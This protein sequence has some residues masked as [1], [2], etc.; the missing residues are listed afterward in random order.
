MKKI[1]CFLL[2]TQGVYAQ[3]DSSS[4]KIDLVKTVF[5]DDVVISSTRAG[6]NT[7]TTF[8]TISKEELN[9]NN[10]GQDL[11]F[12]L[13]NTPGVV[14]T[15]DAG[16]GVGY[17]GI[18]IR[19]SDATRVNVTLNGIPVNDAE[20]Q[21]TYWV[22]LP[23]VVSSA[24]SI[25]IQR[26]IGSSTNGG[27]AFGGTLSMQTQT[28]SQKHFVEANVSMGSFNTFK[29]NGKIGTGIHKGFFAEGSASWITSD[30]YIERA[31]SNLLSYFCQL[32]YMKNNTLLKL[33]YFAGQEKTY[34]AWNG[35]PQDSLSTNR[36]FNDLGTDY[37]QHF[38][39]YKNQTDNYSQDYFQL[40]FAQ[41]LPHHLN[42]NAGLFATLGHG[43]YEEYKA[44]QTFNNY[45]ENHDTLGLSSDLVRQKWLKNVFYGGTF[46]LN[47]EHKNIS[48]TLGGLLGQYRGEN[49]GKVI[50]AQNISDFDKNQKFYDGH[51]VK[52]DFSVYAKFS[53]EILQKVN[54]YID[55]QYRYV[56][57]SANGIDDDKSNYTF[58]NQ[59]HFFNPKAGILYKIKPQHHLY[60]SYA[61][62]NREPNRD[63]V[64]AALASGKTVKPETMHNVEVGYK[65]LHRKYPFTINYY[66]M[67]YK[68][69]LVLT[70]K[71]NDVGNPIKEN[72]PVSSRMGV[73][74][75][76]STNIYSPHPHPLSEGEG[77]N[78]PSPRKVFAINYNFSY[79]LNKIKSFDEYI[80]T[81]DDYYSPLDSLTQIITHKNSNISFSPSIVASLEF[82]AYPVKGLEISLMNKAVS[83]QYL[84]NTSNESRKLK[85][86]FYSNLRI[87][88]KLPLKRDDKEIKFTLLFNNIFN[89]FYES[90]GYTYSERYFSGGEKTDTYTYNY[91]YPQA[92]FNMLGGMSVRF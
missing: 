65:F 14:T 34:Q 18:R 77:G 82:V 39:P 90:N 56:G 45:F 47:Y 50:W 13:D 53:Y 17:T 63:D 66:L 6:D 74:L 24:Q 10:L 22:D 75:S 54:F 28:P 2:L 59:W 38:P 11:P 48:A 4:A 62:G 29:I 52:N 35:V 81:Y 71:L 12:L 33:V 60:A 88:Y 68:D 64:M 37:G 79:S 9:K 42:F 30:G 16:A 3:T 57:Y 20:S 32:G 85:P 40:L 51:S 72:V 87:S 19:G 36:R 91:Y 55:L 92:G 46:A 61:L 27:S 25:Q 31:S 83:K 26:G 78:T 80:Y 1:L 69:Q 76:A 49:F 58:T 89:R 23:D 44:G 70:G 7:P 67:Q 86:F 73:E 84:D 8:Q 21:G 41:Y 15:S 43:Y 5:K